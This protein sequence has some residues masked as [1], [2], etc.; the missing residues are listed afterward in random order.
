MTIDGRLL[1]VL[2]YPCNREDGEIL[3][4]IGN[5]VGNGGRRFGLHTIAVSSQG[6][7]YTSEL[8]TGELVRRFVPADSEG[9]RQVA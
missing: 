6:N 3:G 1:R 4:Q 7:I 8:L 5:I 9:G 2:R